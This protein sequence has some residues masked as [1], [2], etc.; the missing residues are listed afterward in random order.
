MLAEA[1]WVERAFDADGVVP[2]KVSGEDGF[3]LG[4]GGLREVMVVGT[5]RSWAC[6]RIFHA[7]CCGGAD[8]KLETGWGGLVLYGE[9]EKRRAVDAYFE[10]G[11]GLKATVERLGGRPGMNALAGWVRADR[12]YRSRRGRPRTP[13]AV[14]N[15]VPWR[16]VAAWACARPRASMA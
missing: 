6:R 1:L 3:K 7:S 14:R 2:L 5:S 9:A 8:G 4:D 16:I 15:A 11:I 13:V 12:R 10:W